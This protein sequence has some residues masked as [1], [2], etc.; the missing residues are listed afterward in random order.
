M[1]QTIA[2]HYPAHTDTNGVTWY[3]SGPG[4]MAGWTSSPEH[5]DPSYA[6]EATLCHQQDMTPGDRA[7]VLRFARE[8]ERKADSADSQKNFSTVQTPAAHQPTTTR[9]E[10]PAVTEIMADGTPEPYAR[11]SEFMHYPLPPFPERVD[12]NVDGWNRYKL[13]HPTTGKITAYTRATTVAKVT[14]DTYKLERWKQRMKVTAVLKL[15]ACAAGTIELPWI[16]KI[17]AAAHLAEMT[18]LSQEQNND[19]R[20]GLGSYMDLMDDLTGGAEAREHGGAVHDW[21]AELAMG[22]VLL[23]QIPEMFLP[24]AVAYQDAMARAGLIDVPE[25]TERLVLNMKGRETIAG[26]LDGISYCVETGEFFLIDRKT[27]KTLDFSALEYGVQFSIYG[28]ADLMLAIDRSGWEPMPPINDEMAFCIHVPSDQ[29]ERSQVVPFN[30]YTGAESMILALDVREDRRSADKRMLG[31][32]YP[33]PSERS[34]RYVAA[35]QAIQNIHDE[36]EAR[37]IMEEYGDV[38]DDALS[39]LGA[40]CFELL[41][42]TTQKAS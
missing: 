26:R 42:D 36:P 23:H 8:L 1:T 12:V 11:Y 4:R 30:L 22:R 9:K 25:W 27:S 5:A 21:L 33:I 17:E 34:L 38:W 40:A 16:T 37:S 18:R 41:D 24:H 7:A 39:E 35:R 10:P 29:P 2:Q 32:A 14:A 3:M 15:I 28:F 31:Q 13:P 20:G 6:A 19:A